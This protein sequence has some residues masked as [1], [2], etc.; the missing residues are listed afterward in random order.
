MHSESTHL[1]R[2]SW[3]VERRDERERHSWRMHQFK[4]LGQLWAS[5]LFRENL[6]G[7]ILNRRIIRHTCLAVTTTIQASWIH[8]PNLPRFIARLLGS[9]GLRPIPPDKRRSH[10][11]EPSGRGVLAIVG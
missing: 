9:P 11:L 4:A 10:H 7:E 8:A 3:E 6:C 5:F 2:H 1:R